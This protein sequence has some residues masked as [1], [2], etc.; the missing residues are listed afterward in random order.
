MPSP[1]TSL[2]LHLFPDDVRMDLVKRDKFRGYQGLEVESG[3]VQKYQGCR[4][5]L[6]LD[7]RKVA[8]IGVSGDGS[9][10]NAERGAKVMERVVDYVTAFVE[11]FK[12]MDTR[13]V[14]KSG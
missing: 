10:A 12:Q 4:V 3:S 1:G 8:P 13:S 7:T 2:M 5:N 6:Y 11:Q 14:E 9:G